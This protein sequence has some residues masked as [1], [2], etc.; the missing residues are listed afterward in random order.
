MSNPLTMTRAEREGFL[1]D[2]HVG[3][4]SIEQ[5]GE[6]PLTVPIWYDYSPEKGV[7]ILTE[8]GSQKGRALAAAGRFSL[9]AQIEAPP[10]YQ[11]VS[12][13]GAIVETRR[14]DKERDSRPMAH[15]Y[16]G[17]A[18]GDMYVD[19]GQDEGTNLV[20]VMQPERW[21]TVDYGKILPAG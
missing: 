15:R 4:I 9:C 20:F 12:V 19:G 2:V 10:R 5:P 17:D 18:L 14:A 6:G 3:V 11:Y 21:R 8:E 1:A 7:W 16:F 13:T